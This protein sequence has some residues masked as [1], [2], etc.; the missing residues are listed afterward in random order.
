M[1]KRELQ[2][3]APK[4]EKL[5]YIND[6]EA[7]M[8]KAM[9]GSGA[10]VKDTGIRSYDKEVEPSTST[11]NNTGG[12]PQQQDDD[13]DDFEPGGEGGISIDQG[14][15]DPEPGGES[16]TSID[17]D[18]LGIAGGQVDSGSDGSFGFS[19]YS[20]NPFDDDY[21]FNF[22]SILDTLGIAHGSDEASSLHFQGKGFEDET[23]AEYHERMT[24][25]GSVSEEGD[26]YGGV[27]Q[28]PTYEDSQ[29]G[30]HTTQEGADAADE[31]FQALTTAQGTATGTLTDYGADY[32][33]DY[34]SGIESDYTGSYTGEQD[35]AYNAALQGIYDDLMM[36]GVWDQGAYD[37]QLALVDAGVLAD[38]S[39]I[40]TLASDYSGLAQTDYN[41]WEAG[42][43]GEIQT[44]YDAGD[45]EGLN[46]WELEDYSGF[47]GGDY[48]DFNFLD[49]FK[50]IYPDGST[51]Y[52]DP[53]TIADDGEGEVEGEGAVLAPPASM[54]KKKA[55]SKVP[56]YTSSPLASGG[57]S[58]T[59]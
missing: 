37:S 32:G 26:T 56:T 3:K 13:N 44:L 28:A 45:L 12:G 16:T 10:K 19:D 6:F 52:T 54:I 46:T 39:A 25:E 24:G 20:W 35:S 49:E 47:E 2:R 43:T 27:T 36:T 30:I 5:A 59:H 48:A 41:T 51:E 22:G 7:G 33:E 4:G 40:G 14:S 38:T 29:G 23:A 57:S 34:I 53:S 31:Q 9:G 1:N 18:P 8:L 58:S 17:E 21:E 55:R 42:E 15:T 50:K 11:S